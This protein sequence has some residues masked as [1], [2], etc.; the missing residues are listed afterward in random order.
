MLLCAA[1]F[2]FASGCRGYKPRMPPLPLSVAVITLNEEANLRRCLASLGGLAGE[3]VVLD[4]GSTD[5]TGDVAREFGAK[6]SVQDWPGHVAQK[7]RA[8]QLCTRPWV[9]ALDADEALSPELAEAIRALFSAGEPKCAGYHLNRRTFYL[10]SWIWHAWYPEW[11]LRLVHREHARWAGRDPHDRLE[12]DGAS[13]RLA[14]D[15]LHYSYRDLRDHFERTIRYAR[16]SAERLHEEGRRARWH[17]LAC[18]PWAGFARRL[19][20]KQG[21]RDGWRGWVI[22]GTTMFS[23]FAKY[24]FLMERQRVKRDDVPRR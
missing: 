3:I 24:A 13:G 10:G 14:G 16:I 9:L 20:G 2:L 21:F 1:N 6:F 22:A 4:S 18:S 5:R 8:L 15:L 23:V 19:I 12:V 7:N 17:H 11:H